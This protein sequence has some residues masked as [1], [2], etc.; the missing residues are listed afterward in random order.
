[1]TTV[2]RHLQIKG[3]NC[4]PAHTVTFK[5]QTRATAWKKKHRLIL[6][7]VISAKPCGL[8]WQTSTALVRLVQLVFS[9]FLV[10]TALIH[11]RVAMD[12]RF[13]L[14]I[15]PLRTSFVSAWHCFLSDWR[16]WIQSGSDCIQWSRSRAESQTKRKLWINSDGAA[17][18]SNT[19][20]QRN[21]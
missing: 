6:Q 5:D 12:R 21:H 7:R 8:K 19:W 14:W 10:Q 18:W 16:W 9:P 15:I 1:M 11:E 13:L 3:V 4:A 20:R 2:K 17:A